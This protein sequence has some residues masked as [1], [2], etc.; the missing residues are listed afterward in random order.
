MTDRTLI[1]VKPDCVRRGLTGEVLARFERKG[2]KLV[3]LRMLQMDREKA[4][5]FYS[6]HA[7]KPFFGELVQ[8][9]TSGPVAAAM[10]EGRDAVSVVRLIIGSTDS[11]KAPPG[12]VRGDL[13][14]GFTDNCIHASDS[15]ESFDRESKVIFG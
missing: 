2:L 9:V 3:A 15:K 5:E 12:T 11:A 6:V 7:D 13:S 10:L 1:V 4:E 8:F 14:L